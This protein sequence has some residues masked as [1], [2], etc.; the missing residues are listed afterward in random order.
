MPSDHIQ[1]QLFAKI[2]EASHS[3]GGLLG[4]GQ[5]LSEFFGGARIQLS[6][7]D[8][9]TGQ[10]KLVSDSAPG[11]PINDKKTTQ[12]IRSGGLPPIGRL[13]IFGEVVLSDDLIRTICQVLQL[14]IERNWISRLLDTIIQPIPLD[15]TFSKYATT[16]AETVCDAAQARYALIRLL[17]ADPEK[18]FECIGFNDSLGLMTATAQEFNVLPGSNIYE[19]FKKIHDDANSS[20]KPSLYST[21]IREEK[22]RI[23]EIRRLIGDD[24]IQCTFTMPLMLGGVCE[25][26]LG[27][28]YDAQLNFTEVEKNALLTLAN[29]TAVTIQNYINAERLSKLRTSTTIQFV[30]N[31]NQEIIQGLRHS[32]R[33]S[34]SNARNLS[35]VLPN[36][37]TKTKPE[38]EGIY[39]QMIDHLTG[40][41]VSLDS[42]S[43]L[44]TPAAENRDLCDV[45]E[46]FR[47][48]SKI[49]QS[50]LDTKLESGPISLRVNAPS[51]LIIGEPVSLQNAFML[52]MLNS[53]QAFSEVRHR[54][55]EAPKITLNGRLH[56]DSVVLE[57]SDNGPGIKIGKGEILEL[58]DIWQVG[59]TSRRPEGGTGYGLPAVRE[60]IQG[61]HKGD[62]RLTNSEN[63]VS[64]RIVLPRHLV[65]EEDQFQVLLKEFEKKRKLRA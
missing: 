14:V 5:P 42:M 47:E 56:G 21:T 53:L 10:F 40:L 51:L 26:L 18:G 3:N 17:R 13:D 55:R 38:F 45:V 16:L 20:G 48:A 57:L 61:L 60:I 58:D 1:Q 30:E 4:I 34:L 50:Q 6:I 33:Q 24:G 52:L 9:A 46:R 2:G 12:M 43:S 59:K 39:K 41:G 54:A 64:F 49:L 27:I 36:V 8:P 62:I 29:F 11:H 28:G 7:L 44:R 63:G 31:M 23:L 37:I 35:S 19:F 32:A 22:E 25:G 65:G 15:L